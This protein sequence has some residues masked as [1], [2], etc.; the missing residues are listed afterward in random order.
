MKR[1]HRSQKT[2][3]GSFVRLAI[4]PG[5]P[6]MLCIFRGQCRCANLTKIAP[7]DFVKPLL[8]SRSFEP[9]SQAS[10]LKKLE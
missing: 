8:I 9:L 10:A 3:P 7:G 6:Q 1:L 4:L 5:T 2:A